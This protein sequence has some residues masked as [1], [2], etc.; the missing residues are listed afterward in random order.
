MMNL[1]PRFPEIVLMS[2]NTDECLDEY[3]DEYIHEELMSRYNMI[4]NEDII[5]IASL[6]LGKGRVDGYKEL[7]DNLNSIFSIG[8]SEVYL[9][10][11]GNVRGVEYGH[12]GT[13]YYLFRQF[14]ENISDVQKENFLYKVSYG[15]A[16]DNDVLRYTVALGD[17]VKRCNYGA[18]M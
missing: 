4:L 11:R 5:C 3:M 16:T 8:A 14:R 10:K 13:N 1:M 12:D 9:D 2:V 7:S 6:S 18:A 17:F 15:A